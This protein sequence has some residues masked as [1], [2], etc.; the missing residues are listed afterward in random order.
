MVVDFT[1]LKTWS[2]EI[3]E[4]V[5]CLNTLLDEG[6]VDN[7]T[8]ELVSGIDIEDWNMEGSV[9]FDTVEELNE[10][11]QDIKKLVL[12]IFNK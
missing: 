5:N 12:T 7:E 3:T 4:Q 10:Y 1:K 9:E 6:Y 2:S 11:Y 8:L